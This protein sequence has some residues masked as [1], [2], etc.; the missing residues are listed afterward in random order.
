MVSPN[1]AGGGFTAPVSHYRDMNPMKLKWTSRVDISR[2][3]RP[4][5]YR[6]PRRLSRVGNPQRVRTIIPSADR[7]KATIKVRVSFLKLDPR[8]LPDMASK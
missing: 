1:S 7:Q 2:A 8:I 4:T 5:R 3:T 6:Y